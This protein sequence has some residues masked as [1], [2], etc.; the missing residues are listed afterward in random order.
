ME[1]IQG[2]A[3]DRFEFLGGAR[4]FVEDIH[5]V[6]AMAPLLDGLD[7]SETALLCNFMV[8]Y[9]APRDSILMHEGE[10]GDYMLFL[11]TGSAAVLKTDNEG[12]VHRVAV[13]GPGE[14]LG[15]MAMI[16][17]EPRTAT[18][19]SLEPVD[20]ALLTQQAFK[21][22]LIT[23]PRLGNKLLLLM[24]HVIAQRLRVA[25]NQWVKTLPLVDPIITPKPH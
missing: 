19:V 16:D 23:L 15:E 5:D 6:F 21:D 1:A 7:P 2:I 22:V 25:Q 20:F 14:S 17:A 9:A 12:K 24:M 10:L 18:C 3:I 4:N 13:V 8:C 11:L